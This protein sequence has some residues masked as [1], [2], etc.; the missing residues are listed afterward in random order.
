MKNEWN[1]DVKMFWVSDHSKVRELKSLIQI[2]IGIRPENQVLL[3]EGTQ[4]KDDITISYSG[5]YYLRF[6]VLSCSVPPVRNL[7][8]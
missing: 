6:Y 2:E 8:Q 5:K 1:G 7:C 4:L 3:F